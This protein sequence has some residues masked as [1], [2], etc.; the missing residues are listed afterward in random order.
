[1]KYLKYIIALF[2]AIWSISTNAQD[3]RVDAKLDTNVILIGDQV[4]F[5]LKL[6]VPESIPFNWPVLSDTLPDKIEIVNKSKIDTTLTGDGFMNI[7][8]TLTLTTFDTG[9]YVIRPLQFNYGKQNENT[10]ETEP[11]LLNVFTVDVDTTLAIKPIKGPMQAPLSF[12]E[13]WPWAL[14]G[15][16][17]VLLIVGLIYYLKKKK[18][19]QPII[20]KKPKPGLPPHRIAYEELEKLKNEKLWQRDQVKEYHSKLTDILREY[21]E[22]R[23]SINSTEMTTWETIRAFSGAKI[24][25]SSL[26]KL[27]EILELADLAKFAKYKPRPEDHEKSM[28]DAEDFV[29]QTTTTTPPNQAEII[30]AEVERINDKPEIVNTEKDQT[31]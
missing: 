21:I 12:A 7:E 20:A 17:F 30:N 25:K 6:Q 15:I 2:I 22:G 16:L 23:F 4:G 13:I 19:N 18:A 1:M 10:V 27:R 8:Q 26:G 3:V 9:Y 5:K 28:V 11:Y 29:K 14:A 31:R 24:D